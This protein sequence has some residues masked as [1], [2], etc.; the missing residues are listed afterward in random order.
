MSKEAQNAL[1]RSPLLVLGSGERGARWAE[2]HQTG[3]LSP[4]V[5]ALDIAQKKDQTDSPVRMNADVFQIGNIFGPESVR[6]I[7]ADFLLNGIAVADSPLDD[8]TDP[9]QVWNQ[10]ISMVDSQ[11]CPARVKES[12]EA[13]KDQLRQNSD[14]QKLD[15]DEQVHHLGHTMKVFLQQEALR[16]MW[17][18]LEPQGKITLIDWG[19]YMNIGWLIRPGELETVLNDDK[20]DVRMTIKKR[21]YGDLDRSESIHVVRQIARERNEAIPIVKFVLE[22]IPSGLPPIS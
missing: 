12:F 22:K 17:D 18:V 3:Y 21:L 9:T 7:H 11:F 15:P 16:Q 20:H 1:S 2:E 13:R 5:I 8:Q 4:N 19:D 10:Y 6:G 14:F